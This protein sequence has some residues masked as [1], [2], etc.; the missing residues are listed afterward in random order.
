METVRR[1]ARAAATIRVFDSAEKAAQAIGKLD[2]AG[3]DTSKLSIIGREEPS[4][5]HE[6]GIALAG[7]QATLWG[8]RSGLWQGH[9]DSPGAVALAWVPFIGHVVAVG[10][11]ASTLVGAHRRGLVRDNTALA[12]MLSV[13]GTSPGELRRYPRGRA[14]RADPAPHSWPR[15]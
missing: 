1:H 9:G 8:R 6:L 5:T 4:E 13:A 12:R 10:P 2:E 7:E 14:R 11:A 3:F 15:W